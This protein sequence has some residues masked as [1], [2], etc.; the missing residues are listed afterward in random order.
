MGLPRPSRLSVAPS[1]M[2]LLDVTT[3][4]SS[5]EKMYGSARMDGAVTTTMKR[6][7]KRKEGKRKISTVVAAEEL[8]LF[9]QG[10]G[11]IMR[12]YITNLRSRK[13]AKKRRG[14]AG[15]KSSKRGRQKRSTKKRSSKKKRL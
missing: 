14:A 8:E 9:Q 13:K 12:C 4:L 3:F 2:V 10:Y 1:V 5:L 6:Y 15:R 7:Q 11:D